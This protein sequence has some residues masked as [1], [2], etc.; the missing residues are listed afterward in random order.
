MSRSCSWRVRACLAPSRPAFRT[1]RVPAGASP[2]AGGPWATWWPVDGVAAVTLV[3]TV[4]TATRRRRPAPKRA[5]RR[6]GT[7]RGGG[8]SSVRPARGARSSGSPAWRTALR[9]L[10]GPQSEDVWGVVFLVL[11]V[12]CALGIYSDLAGPVGRGVDHGAAD[13]FGWARG[14]LP[15]AL[16]VLGWVLVR[17]SGGPASR[18]RSQVQSRGGRAPRQLPDGEEVRGPR[19]RSGSPSAAWCSLWPLPA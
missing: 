19:L 5:T 6:V 10:L 4:A 18:R 9:R 2:L 3:T 13:V 16:A 17:G 8:R 7:G 11:A 12:L 15:P 14:F 1:P